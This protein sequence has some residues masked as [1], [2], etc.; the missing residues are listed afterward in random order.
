MTAFAW[1]MDYGISTNPNRQ[2][3]H[4]NTML[5]KAVKKG[6]TDLV[7]TLI[8]LEHI[9]LDKSNRNGD[10]ALV[11]AIK[12][13]HLHI[14][15]KLISAGANL[16]IGNSLAIAIT[17]GYVDLAM[18]IVS[19]GAI[20]NK[21]DENDQ[22]PLT[23]ATE[24][25]YTDLVKHMLQSTDHIIKD[26]IK[27]LRPTDYKVIHK[28]CLNSQNSNGETVLMK[29][30]K[31]NNIMLVDQI[32]AEGANINKRNNNGDTAIMIAVK[33]N[34]IELVNRLLDARAN[35]RL[36]NANGHLAIDMT[37]DEMI[38]SALNAHI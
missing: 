35:I 26:L 17:Y 11:L 32:I 29:A 21:K 3:N 33:M 36:R 23:I 20:C 38:I 34:S 10:T 7:N 30:V 19:M 14:A 27:P 4:G 16:N 31:S 15:D 25:N 9:S 12:H 1:Y 28:A 2:D 13:G 6:D 37:D 18:R 8:K 22:T 5:M 24:R